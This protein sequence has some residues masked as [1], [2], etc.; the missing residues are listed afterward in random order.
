M[1]QYTD[2]DIHAKA[3]ELGLIYDSQEL[4]RN[5][6]SRVIA[7]LAEEQ[8]TRAPRATG[9]EPKVAGEIVVQ[10]RGPILIDGEPLPWLV[11]TEPMD[12]RLA[13]DGSGTVRLTLAANTIQIIKAEPKKE[14]QS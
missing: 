13:D 12:I 9:P 7:A 6:R 10:P 2:Q 5:L 1:L 14:E 4:P 3:V 8:R 11:T